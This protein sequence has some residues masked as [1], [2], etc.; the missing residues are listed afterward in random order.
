MSNWLHLCRNFTYLTYW[1]FTAT[2]AYFLVALIENIVC[3]VYG[4]TLNSWKIPHFFFP[5]VICIELV[6]NSVFWLVFFPFSI[7]G[8]PNISSIDIA[9]AIGAHFLPMLMLLVDLSINTVCFWTI[10]RAA[11]T[12]I[13]MGCYLIVNVSYTLSKQLLTQRSMS[14]TIFSLMTTGFPMSLLS[15]V[16]PQY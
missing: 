14:S 11:T 12:L 2:T 4:T 8:N 13:L 5:D 16:R 10:K 6:I 7:K 9:Q 1:G 15:D 3:R